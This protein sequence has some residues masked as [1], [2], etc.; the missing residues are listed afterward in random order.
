MG[1]LFI[2]LA[3]E[4]YLPEGIKSMVSVLACSDCSRTREEA[5]VFVRRIMGP[6]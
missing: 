5:K 2:R 6:P 1:A 3:L 4:S